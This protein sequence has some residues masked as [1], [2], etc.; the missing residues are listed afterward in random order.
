M[1]WLEDSSIHA[2]WL[3][4]AGIFCLLSVSLLKTCEATKCVQHHLWTLGEMG[5]FS[6]FK[7]CSCL[8][9][10]YFNSETQCDIMHTYI[11]LSMCNAGC[12][13]YSTELV[14][15]IKYGVS[16]FQLSWT[17]WVALQRCS[18]SCLQLPVWGAVRIAFMVVHQAWLSKLGFEPS[19]CSTGHFKVN[20]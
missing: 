10:V 15:W 9:I 2:M 5:L 16:C 12:V 7:I 18:L 17:T 1:S 6:S 14:I 3:F 13:Q 11:I 20:Y 4:L 8:L 19:L